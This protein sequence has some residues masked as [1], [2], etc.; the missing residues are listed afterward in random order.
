MNQKILVVCPIGLGNYIM[1]SP[2]LELLNSSLSSQSS[3]QLDILAL[4]TGIAELA[5]CQGIFTNIYCWD[6]DKDKLNQG[7]KILLKL[8]K[9]GYHKALML[10]PTENW[11]F[12]WYIKACGIKT[13]VYPN[14]KDTSEHDVEVNYKLVQSITDNQV[15]KKIIIPYPKGLVAKGS[16][17]TLLPNHNFYVLHP[18]SS[19]ERGMAGKRWETSKFAQLI[20]NLYTQKGLKC[21][22]IGGPEEQELRSQVTSHC[23]QKEAVQSSRAASLAQTAYLMSRA[24]FF[25]GN[26]SGLMHLAVSLNKICMVMFGPT[27]EKETGPYPLQKHL[28]I[29]EAKHYPEYLTKNG[30]LMYRDKGGLDKLKPQDVTSQILEFLKEGIG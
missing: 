27:N 28:I 17:E 9:T 1:I 18:G 21:V 4:K 12:Q 2:A 3:C 29:R 10:Y 15:Q 19:S 23:L 11:K 13:I 20:D 30:R 5:K 22:L 25:I 6:P 14:K 7:L 24:D 26:D 8:R 16:K